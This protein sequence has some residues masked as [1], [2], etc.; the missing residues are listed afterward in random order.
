MGTLINISDNN[1]SV[2][3]FLLNFD[4][5]KELIESLHKLLTRMEPM[6]KDVS[7]SALHSFRHGLGDKRGSDEESHTRTGVLS[8]SILSPFHQSG[9]GSIPDALTC[10][11]SYHLHVMVDNLILNGNDFVKWKRNLEI[12]LE[13][14]FRKPGLVTLSLKGH[15]ISV[16][17]YF[18]PLS[19]FNFNFPRKEILEWFDHQNN[20]SSTIKLPPNLHED[21][22]WMGL[23]ICASFSIHEHPSS[24]SETSLKILCHLITNGSCVNVVPVHFITID[25][26]SWLHVCG[27]VWLTY[28]PNA[29]ITDLKEGSYVSARI[30]NRIPGLVVNNCSIRLLYKQDF[31]EFKQAI[32]QCW[33]SFFDDLDPIFRFVTDE[34]AKLLHHDN[35]PAENRGTSDKVLGPINP[36]KTNQVLISLFSFL[37]L[38]G[39]LYTCSFIL[40]SLP[41][42]NL[43]F[44]LSSFRLL[45]RVCICF[46]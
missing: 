21:N 17:K 3:C 12:S 39:V 38:I 2:C 4:R 16:L 1:N 37:S 23:A 44:I 6:K 30:Y 19:P 45:S 7:T 22:N 26:F 27:F 42:I 5:E 24:L 40:E 35:R 11:Y 41:F 20:R 43:F 32:I 14:S 25:K 15:I 10:H 9:E 28:V 13:E 29:L 46:A 18:N 33:T 36:P 8:H 31:P 34:D